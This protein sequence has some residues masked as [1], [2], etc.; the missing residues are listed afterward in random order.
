[1]NRWGIFFFFQ[2]F[3]ASFEF[4]GGQ[5]R[6]FRQVGPGQKWAAYRERY[7]PPVFFW[8]ERSS[9]I[10]NIVKMNKSFYIPHIFSVES[11]PRTLTNSFQ[12]CLKII[13]I[14]FEKKIN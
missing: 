2:F 9:P 1:M 6:G 4:R 5:F 13:L 8:A 7:R 11:L 14:T 10:R 12:N 3:S